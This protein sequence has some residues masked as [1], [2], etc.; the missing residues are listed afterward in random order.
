MGVWCIPRKKN[1]KLT[2]KPSARCR[3]VGGYQS[4]L[5][6]E[7]GL[8]TPGEDFRVASDGGGAVLFFFGHSWNL[9]PGAY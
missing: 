4:P 3:E 1:K 9:N 5:K 6:K 7:G 8:I 2:A